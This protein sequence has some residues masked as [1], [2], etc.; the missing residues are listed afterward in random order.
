M[1]FHLL[2]SIVFSG[3]ALMWGVLQIMRALYEHGICDRPLLD[4]D[5]EGAYCESSPDAYTETT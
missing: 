3:F 4:T 2:A 1:F 5:I